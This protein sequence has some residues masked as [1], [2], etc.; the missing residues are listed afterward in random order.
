MNAHLP[1]PQ[2]VSVN[3]SE[4]VLLLV[5]NFFLEGDDVLGPG[6]IYSEEGVVIVTLDPT[7]QAELGIRYRLWLGSRGYMY[8]GHRDITRRVRWKRVKRQWEIARCGKRGK[9][10]QKARREKQSEAQ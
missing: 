6:N 10:G 5:P 7:K 3:F 1:Q 2:S 4:C 9:A 8:H